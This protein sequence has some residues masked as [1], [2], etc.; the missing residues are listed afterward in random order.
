MNQTI[1][2]LTKDPPQR[3]MVPTNLHRVL[4]YLKSVSKYYHP[5]RVVKMS[6]RKSV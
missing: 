2:K 5:P 4:I 6:S 1:T 3:K